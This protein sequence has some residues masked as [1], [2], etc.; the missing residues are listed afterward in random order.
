MSQR[1]LAGRQ[2]C[3]VWMPSWI[4]IDSTINNSW[5]GRCGSKCCEKIRIARL[6]VAALLDVVSK[7]VERYIVLVVNHEPD[8]RA[9]HKKLAKIFQDMRF[10]TPLHFRNQ[11]DFLPRRPRLFVFEAGDVIEPFAPVSV[12]A[13]RLNTVFCVRRV[14]RHS[15]AGA[16][17]ARQLS[18]QPVAVG[19][20][21]EGNDIV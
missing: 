8:L 14:R 12:P 2:S 6:G 15:L 3:L 18:F 21:D 13:V 20:D 10:A 16:N 9:R 5:V 4:H 17:P 1:V 11:K 19:A 7:L